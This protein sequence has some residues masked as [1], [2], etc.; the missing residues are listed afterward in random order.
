V[1]VS[2]KFIDQR[3]IERR[4]KDEVRA[5]ASTDGVHVRYHGRAGFL[6]IVEGCKVTEVG[7]ELGLDS[8]IVDITHLT[9]WVLPAFVPLQWR[10]RSG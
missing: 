3:D 5:L 6:Y 1:H 10:R 9:D 2:R 7:F 4:G 8:F